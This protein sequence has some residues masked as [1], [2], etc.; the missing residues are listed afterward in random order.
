MLR[1]GLK[2]H[3]TKITSLPRRRLY[4]VASS[5]RE[6]ENVQNVNRLL[7]AIRQCDEAFIV[8]AHVEKDAFQ[9]IDPLAARS[10]YAAVLSS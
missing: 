2:W 1:F 4:S 3:T 10:E 8:F 9:V 6:S 7:N 5:A